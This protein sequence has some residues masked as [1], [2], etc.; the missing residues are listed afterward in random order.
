MIEFVPPTGRGRSFAG[1]FRVRLGDSGPSGLLRLDGLTRM[2][3]DVAT[4]DAEDTQVVNEDIWV[5]RRTA[6]RVAEGGQWPRYLDQLRLVTWCGGY[7]AAWAERRTN[8]YREDALLLEAA[9]LWVPIDKT[10]HPVR[11]RPSFHDVYG[12]A[13]NGRKVSGRVPDPVVAI[14]ALRSKWSL[15]VSDLDII[16]HVNNAAIWQ[17]V[18]EVIPGPPAY[19]SMIHHGSLEAGDHIELFSSESGVWLVVE[20][21]VRVS[22]EFSF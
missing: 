12:E 19:V 9:S 7:G 3:Q 2:L 20:G 21:Q 14:D 8:V 17:A 22:V 1:L 11:I 16:G 4:D 6:V 10:G 5:V 15:R 13:L 18:S